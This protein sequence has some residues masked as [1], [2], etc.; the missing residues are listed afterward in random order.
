M[1]LFGLTTRHFYAHPNTDVGIAKYVKPE[2]KKSARSN[3][4][5]YVFRPT[6]YASHLG[7]GAGA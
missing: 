1:I 7:R 3:L 5:I 6:Q 2:F 4:T